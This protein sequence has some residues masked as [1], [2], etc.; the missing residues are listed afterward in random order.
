M[1]HDAQATH[2]AHAL[3]TMLVPTLRECCGG[4]LGSVEWF[5]AAWQRGGAS[6]GWARWKDDAGERGVMVKLPVGPIEYRW[7]LTLARCAKGLTPDV[8]AH[9]T[10][11]GAY[12]MAWVIVEKIEGD[13]LWHE[14]THGKSESAIHDLLDADFA[15]QQ[16]AGDL[17]EGD[18]SRP[19]QPDWHALVERS[20]MTCR[21]GAIP[22]A[23]KWNDHLH[24]LQRALDVLQ[25]MWEGRTMAAW[26]HGDLHPGN[27]IRRRDGAVALIDLALVHPGHWMEDALYLERQFWG[28]SHLLNGIKPVSYIAKKR[29]E[30]GLACDDYAPIANARRLLMAGGA[31]ALVEHEGNPKYLAAA[32]DVIERLLPQVHH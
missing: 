9:G 5:R 6:T 1:E 32:L 7:C 25:R 31:P 14:V 26:C 20:R 21:A 13:A 28:Q 22:H 16:A 12:D 3:A 19:K 4:K 18:T 8:L 10:T 15:F 30:A 11:L 27:A 17:E 29:R 24:R 23:Q 2:D